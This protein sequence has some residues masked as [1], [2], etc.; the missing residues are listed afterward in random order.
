MKLKPSEVLRR[1]KEIV[2]ARQASTIPA[3]IYEVI[4]ETTNRAESLFVEANEVKE[5]YKWRVGPKGVSELVEAFD[6]A[7]ALAKEEEADA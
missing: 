7:I 4:R 3:A 2:V 6:R 1:A 5:I